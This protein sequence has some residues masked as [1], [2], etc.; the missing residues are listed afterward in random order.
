VAPYP[1]KTI[2]VRA[3]HPRAVNPETL[4][5][6]F[7]KHSVKAQVVEEVPKAVE[8]ALSQAKPNDLICATG[9]LFVVAEVTE[10]MLKGT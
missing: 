8:S 3:H 5:G 2:I 4:V 7:A 9:S 1:H 10:Y 6:G